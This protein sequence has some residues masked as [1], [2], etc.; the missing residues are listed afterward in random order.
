MS[1]LTQVS[2]AVNSFVSFFVLE[3]ENQTTTTIP[4]S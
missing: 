4:F 2:V 1:Q 3:I